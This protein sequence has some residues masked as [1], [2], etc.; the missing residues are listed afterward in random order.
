MATASVLTKNAASVLVLSAD[1]SIRAR[2]RSALTAQ[3]WE[4]HEADGGA[5]A[6][7]LMERTQPHATLL[8]GALPDLHLEDFAEEARSSHPAMDLIAL[9]G[10]LAGLTGGVRSPRRGELLQVLRSV[11]EEATTTDT[12]VSTPP[13]AAMGF[14]PRAMK[15]SSLRSP[16]Q[17]PA[18]VDLG[19]AMRLPELIGG[20]DRMLEVSR[21][22]RLVAKR[23]TTVLIQGPTGTG[24]ELVAHAVHRLSPRADQP[25]IALNCAA[26]PEALLEAELFGHARGA[27][28][29]AVQRRTGRIEVANGG[30][31]F[32]DE[33][34][35]MP[36]AL[37]S[38]L[39]RFL[40]SGELQRVG[41]NEPVRVDVRI[42]AATHQSLARRAQEGSFRADLY[43]R[44]AV[45]PVQT[46]IST[47][48]RMGV[49]VPTTGSTSTLRVQNMAA[50]FIAATLPPFAEPG[51]KLDV[52]VSSAGDAR[53]LNGGLL[54][55][56]PLYGPDGRIYA[57]SQGPIVLG[58]YAAAA[59]GNAKVVNHPTTGR[60]P[61]GAMV[62]R[63]VPLDLARLPSLSILLNDAD[64]RTAER[65][66]DAINNDLKRPLAHAADS[67]RVDLHPQSGEDLPALLARVEAVEIDTFPRAKVVV[68]ERTGTVVIGGDVRLQPVS[69]LHG[70]LVVNVVSDFVISQPG[71]LSNG[72]TQTV[73]ET[74]IDAQDKPVNQIVLKRGA[75]VDDLVQ[76]LQGI[77]ASARDV[78]SILQAMKEA[79]AL[80][81]ELEVL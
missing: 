32:L 33:I 74:R 48:Q 39:L 75:T 18:V 76:E 71:P 17:A 14:P 24:K 46:L 58:G 10:T 49:N 77:G 59:N 30:T 3:R 69:I 23:T 13:P 35:E 5:A 43:Y 63:G 21:R 57:Q 47:L 50:V 56:T 70:G 55:M 28:T 12:N 66:A 81:A 19:A 16:A 52:T 51:T 7:L 60:I 41:E 2:L 38:K 22:I 72:T 26:I 40:E 34:G 15:A 29:G 61:G 9:D 1:S 80:E 37:Q 78:I 36:L 45:F 8:D 73:Q 42:V 4:V 25:F 68:N 20:S 65:M 31:L 11:C 67:R 27:F 53:S 44:L 79:G 62:E 6:L 64:F 54:L